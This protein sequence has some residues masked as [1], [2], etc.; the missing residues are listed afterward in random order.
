MQ[1][2]KTKNP[3]NEKGRQESMTISVS[4]LPQMYIT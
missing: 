1:K 3:K 2:I 4:P